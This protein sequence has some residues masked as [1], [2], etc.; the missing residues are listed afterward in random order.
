MGSSIHIE[1]LLEKTGLNDTDIFIIQD[2][3]NTKK[4]T[5]F[6]L[7]SGLVQDT[8]EPSEHR[9]YSSKKVNDLLDS[10]KSIN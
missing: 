3:E 6:N 10:L 8:E 5:V 7:R 4:I 2:D 1:D 9:I